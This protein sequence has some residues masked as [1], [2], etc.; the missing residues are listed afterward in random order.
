MNESIVK[1][2]TPFVIIK[3]KRDKTVEVSSGYTI[4]YKDEVEGR[5]SCFIPSFDIYFSATSIDEVKTKGTRI[6]KIYI[7]YYFLHSK[8]R[9]KDFV[10]QIH[11]LGFKAINDAITIKN[12]INNIP[13]QAKFKSSKGRS[14]EFLDSEKIDVESEME[15]AI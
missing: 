4:Y 2:F 12:L 10:L 14:S 8:N 15:M 3:P 13:T 1:E 5:I 9:L 7:D 6:V 11:K